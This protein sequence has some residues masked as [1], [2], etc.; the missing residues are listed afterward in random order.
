MVTVAKP[1]CRDIHLT[2]WVLSG[3]GNSEFECLPFAWFLKE[4]DLSKFPAMSG[5][6]TEILKKIYCQSGFWQILLIQKPSY[7]ILCTIQEATFRITIHFCKNLQRLT[8]SLSW[9]VTRPFVLDLLFTTTYSIH[10]SIL[11]NL[12]C[13]W[14]RPSMNALGRKTYFNWIGQCYH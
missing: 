12:N 10:C 8:S 4:E 11:A 7:H 2:S 1:S 5:Q 9:Q 3:L 6:E 14:W 13:L